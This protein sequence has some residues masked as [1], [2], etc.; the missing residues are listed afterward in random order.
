MRRDGQLEYHENIEAFREAI[1]FTES[2][3]GFNARLVEKDYYC[4]L[5]LRDLTEAFQQGLVFKGGT[6][7]SKVHTDFYRLSEDLDFVISMEADARRSA[8]RRR[9]A[10]LKD[11]MQGLCERL[12]CFYVNN[13]LKGANDSKQYI[14]QLSYDS[15]VTG[16]AEFIKLEISLREP[17]LDSVEHQSAQ[18]M[19]TDPLHTAPVLKPIP[20]NVLSFHETFAE[21]FRAAMTRRTPAIRDYYDI[22][23]AVRSHR[24]DPS[25]AKL[26]K[27]LHQKLAPCVTDP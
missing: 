12:P 5:V 8:R 3:T 10:P 11:L 19:L 22:D 6:C 2:S 4:S 24:L 21:K 15:A 20:V 7:L 25:D 18:T 23:Y 1:N 27:L 17:I 9:I 13:S 26:L 14:G 16:H